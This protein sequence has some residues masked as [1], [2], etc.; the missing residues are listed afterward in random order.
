MNTYVVGHKNP[1]TDSFVSAIALAEL[2]GYIPA[3]AGDPNKETKIVLSHFGFEIP[4]LIPAEEKQVILVD[5]NEPSQIHESVKVEEVIG[6]Y[7]HHKLGGVSTKMPIRVRIEPV[8]A[9]STI[10]AKMYKEQGK[11]L[12]KELAGLLLAGIISDTNNLKS[13]TTTE[14]DVEFYNFLGEASG[15]DAKDLAE[16]MFAAKSDISDI[17]TEEL[18]ESDYKVFDM[19]GKKVGIGVWETVLPEKVL[20]RKEEIIA[21]LKKN[22]ENQGLDLIFFAVVDILNNN[23]DLLMVDGDEEVVAQKAFSGRISGSVMELLGIV[24]RKKEIA[25]AIEKSV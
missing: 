16:E 12:N 19:N 17:S 7:D 23:S 11:N 9:T 3:A 21:Q 8:G 24:S 25:P 13:P 10:V 14:E 22:K 18:L 20:E 4:T 6:I 1:D 5:H 2:F 15:V